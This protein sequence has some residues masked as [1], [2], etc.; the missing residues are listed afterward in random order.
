ME[1]CEGCLIKCIHHTAHSNGFIPELVL[2]KC[3]CGMCLV[4]MV[5]ANRC[6][7]FDK[8]ITKTLHELAELKKEYTNGELCKWKNEHS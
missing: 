5:C 7:E 6:E 1:H 8:Y 3:P 4:K 2:T